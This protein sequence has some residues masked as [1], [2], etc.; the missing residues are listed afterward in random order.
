MPVDADEIF[1][2]NTPLALSSPN[3]IA[4]SFIY[5]GSCGSR[6]SFAGATNGT[7]LTSR[8]PFLDG[9]NQKTAMRDYKTTGHLS[10]AS[11]NMES[12]KPAY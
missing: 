1:S 10:K 7:E 8:K 3:S 4:D 2:E 9:S 5:W 12:S 6:N 11:A